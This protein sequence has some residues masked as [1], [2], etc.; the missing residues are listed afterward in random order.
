MPSPRLFIQFACY[1]NPAFLVVLP[2]ECPECHE[3]FS[4]W[5]AL[6]ACLN[7]WHAHLEQP[8]GTNMRTW[9]ALS[10]TCYGYIFYPRHDQSAWLKDR[11]NSSRHLSLWYIYIYMQHVSLRDK[12]AS[13]SER[14]ILHAGFRSLFKNKAKSLQSQ[15][16]WK[17]ARTTS[18]TYWWSKYSSFAKAQRI[19]VSAIGCFCKANIQVVVQLNWAIYTAA[20][21]W[22]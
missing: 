4:S 3:A 10:N 18:Q 8:V 20:S 17:C 1:C 12:N 2:A 15:P 11:S 21:I 22:V 6:H 13:V 7:L 16:C 14:G 5:H 19:F 9:Q